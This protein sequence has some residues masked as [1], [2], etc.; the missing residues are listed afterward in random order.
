MILRYDNGTIARF[1]FFYT[2]P[3]KSTVYF[4]GNQL[5]SDDGKD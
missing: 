1:P 4:E 2:Q 5:A 3:N